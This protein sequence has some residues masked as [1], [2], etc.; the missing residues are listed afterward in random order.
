MRTMTGMEDQME[1]QVGNTGVEAL[2]A[3]VKALEKQARLARRVAA[4]LGLAAAALAGVGAASPGRGVPDTI[5]ARQ[6]IAR[7]LQGN[8]RMVIGV[9]AHGAG[10]LALNDSDGSSMLQSRG[11]A[12]LRRKDIDPE[13]TS[14]P[15]IVLRLRR[16]C[17]EAH[18]GESCHALAEFFDPQRNVGQGE[19][20]DAAQARV[21]YEK[22]CAAGFAAGCQATRERRD[23]R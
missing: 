1:E 5:E 22:A 20:T 16:Q 3:R 4:A 15:Q 14:P 19:P 13:E 8:V 12:F 23:R 7:D 18:D 2:A 9:D 11:D 21:Y 10:Y 6:F 17:E